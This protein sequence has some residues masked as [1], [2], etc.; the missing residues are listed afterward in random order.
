MA[1]KKN[2]V[3]NK[4]TMDAFPT[5]PGGVVW[6]NYISDPS[7]RDAQIRNSAWALEWGADAVYEYN[8]DMLPASFKAAHQDLFRYRRGGGYWIWKPFIVNHALT[9]SGARLVVYCD[10]GSQVLQTKNEIEAGVR[11]VGFTCVRLDR[12]GYDNAY[13]TK[14]DA[15]LEL[16]AD[17]KE[18]HEMKQCTCTFFAVQTASVKVRS[19]LREWQQLMETRH[20]L[21]DDSPSEAPE[22]AVFREHRHSQSIL[23]ILIRQHGISTANF[24]S[25]DCYK[26]HHFGTGTKADNAHTLA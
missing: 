18:F 23:T 3:S 20:H 8:Y 24:V 17:T 11:N 22:L 10:S 16:N 19:M 2:N 12:P 9:H 5:C 14:R 7:W 4:Q 25:M 21:V 6:V 1:L 26:Q 13:W 15:F